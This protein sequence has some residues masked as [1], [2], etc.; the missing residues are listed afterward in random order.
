MTDGNEES[1]GICTQC[2]FC[3]TGQLFDRAEILDDEHPR[4]VDLGFELGSEARSDG[5]RQHY[6]GL[7]CHMLSGTRCTV[8]AGRPA[9]CAAFRCELLRSVESGVTSRDEA[10]ERIATAKTLLARLAATMP[11]DWSF[12][13]ARQ[14]WRVRL[15][16]PASDDDEATPAFMLQMSLT[17]IF[18]DRYFYSEKKRQLDGHA[19]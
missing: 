13:H 12:P 18:L 16:K 15:A 1:E 14:R 3:C 7:P 17:N 8:Y 6:I 2:G 11:A 10:V 9:G 4:L 5:G 19:S